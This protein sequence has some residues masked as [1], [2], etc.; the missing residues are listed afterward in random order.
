MI[1]NAYAV[2][3]A[4]LA[5]LRF[6]AGAAV[7]VLAGTALVA[8]RRA[9][10]VEDRK[11][12]EDRC[13]LL[14]MLGTLLIFL[15][16]ASWPLLYLLLQSYV[17]QWPGVMC[18]YGVTR[19]GAGSLGAAGYL[20]ALVH[21]IEAGKPALVFVTGA[22]LVLYRLNHWTR[23]SALIGRVLV[24]LLMVG[25]VAMADAAAES[26]YLVIPKR[27]QYLSVGCCSVAGEPGLLN[28]RQ[29]S[30]DLDSGEAPRLTTA[31]YGSQFA[32][33]LALAPWSLATRWRPPRAW[34]APLL[35]LSI[36][37]WPLAGWFLVGVAAP[38]LLG[39][40]H[41]HCAY[42]L[43]T[44]APDSLLAVFMFVAASFCVGWACV[45]AWLGNIPETEDAVTERVRTLLY[46]ALLGYTGS[47]LMLSFEMALA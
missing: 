20:P 45:A 32:L 2:L 42:D 25:L 24:A 40:P 39:L 21:A 12:L 47:V 22:W 30:A 46:L 38:V 4:F 33:V 7:A 37:S 27:E 16:V 34:L 36:V 8:A 5:V 35:V 28:G 17:P 9:Q 14:F 15:N 31:Y 11:A 23:A 44:Q 29:P 26:A 3:D 10:S 18:I 13:Y 41:H 19:I 43:I 1:L 6:G